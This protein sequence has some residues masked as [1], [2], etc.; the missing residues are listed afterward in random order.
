MPDMIDSLSSFVVDPSVSSSGVTRGT[1]ILFHL[2]EFG[3]VHIAPS[4]PFVGGIPY[5]SS[6]HTIGIPSSGGDPR[7]VNI[8]G[9][10]NIM[11]Y[12]PSYFVHV[13]SN[14][15]FMTHPPYNLHG[16]LGRNTAY[17]HVVPSSIGYA[18]Y[19]GYVPPYVSGG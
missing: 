5:T 15:F 16:S 13:P 3:N 12:V 9:T 19:G 2:D 11:S 8:G 1:T 17:S 4:T 18:M 10:S 7:H 6:R 14:A